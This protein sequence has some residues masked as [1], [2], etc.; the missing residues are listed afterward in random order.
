ME[1]RKHLKKKLDPMRYEH[2]LGVAYTCQALAMRYEYDL[3]K[4]ELA[5]L[6]HDCAKRYDGAT[7]LKKCLDRGIEVSESEA[8]DPSL[9]HAKLGAW[10]AGAKYGVD[11]PEIADA[12][13]CH[14]TGKPGMTL[15]DKILY[16]A[17]YIEPRRYKAGAL[18]EMRKLAFVDLDLACFSIME[19]SLEYLKSKDC[20][21]DPMTEIACEDMRRVVS[22]KRVSGEQNSTKE[23][24]G[25]E[26]V[27]KEVFT[28]GTVKGNG[29]ARGRSI[30]REKRRRHQNHRH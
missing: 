6:L 11:D 4:A 27:K 14:T 30:G 22:E 18:P 5:G 7:L 23:D 2:T 28:V 20:P 16:V 8:R 24:C 9:L 19:S 10:M 1:I 21:I 25:Q 3:D 13:A 12:I 29:K 15:L 26:T 17:D